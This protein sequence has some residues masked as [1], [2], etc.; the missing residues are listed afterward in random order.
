MLTRF[1][2]REE[3]GRALAAHLLPLAPEHPV[4]LAVPRGGVPVA[5]VV[6][7]TIGATLDVIVVRKLG[8]P[9]QPELAI[10][11]VAEGGFVYLDSELIQMLGIAHEELAQIAEREG[12]ELDRRVRLYRGERSAAEV[13]D[14]TVIVVDD[15][16]ARGASVRAAVRALRERHPRRIVV[17]VPVIAPDT[18]RDLRTEVNE[19]VCLASPQLF[20]A[21]GYWY[22]DFSP[23]SDER[24]L[25]LLA[26][27]RAG[28]EAVREGRLP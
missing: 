28:G 7:R 20:G 1:R 19:V 12:V 26:P 4:V 27:A 21:V 13:K 18:L 24:A 11:A 8:A 22:E 10:G 23:V 2:N 3:A 14:R 6:A 9:G 17:A 25:A 15:G 16:V 5:A